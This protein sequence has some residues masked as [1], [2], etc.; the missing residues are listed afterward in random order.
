M[1][2]IL[3]PEGVA[4]V[5]TFARDDGYYG[6]W[7]ANTRDDGVVEDPHTGILNQLFTPALLDQV[8]APPLRRVAASTLVFI[9]EAASESW[10]RRFLIHLYRKN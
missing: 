9:D 10:T 2:R 3:R 8:F 1:A 6:R 7:L 4:V 5:V